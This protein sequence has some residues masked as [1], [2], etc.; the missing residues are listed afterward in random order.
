MPFARKSRT[1]LHRI[2]GRHDVRRLRGREA[3]RAAK[4]LNGIRFDFGADKTRSIGA[5]IGDTKV[6]RRLKTRMVVTA[7]G[8]GDHKRLYCEKMLDGIIMVCYILYI[9]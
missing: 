8:Y 3:K 1:A 7:G 4:S 9:S 2:Y 5:K 6:D